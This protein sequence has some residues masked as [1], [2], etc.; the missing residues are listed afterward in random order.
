M[1]LPAM[2][3]SRLVPPTPISL[4]FWCLAEQ[5]FRTQPPGSLGHPRSCS[6]QLRLLTV[7]NDV[8]LPGAKFLVNCSKQL[9]LLSLPSWGIYWLFHVFSTNTEGFETLRVLPGIISR[10]QFHTHTQ[11][12]GSRD[13]MVPV[14]VMVGEA[15]TEEQIQPQGINKRTG[16]WHD[17]G[18]RVLCSPCPVYT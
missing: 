11:K 14:V 6:I 7:D 1:W 16:T 3:A 17:K 5:L 13:W 18:S 9:H 12:N 2:S 15:F 10:K 4:V 8:L